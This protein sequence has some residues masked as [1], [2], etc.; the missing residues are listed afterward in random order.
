M[1]RTLDGVAG[2]SGRA[3]YT[4]LSATGL[5]TGTALGLIVGTGQGLSPGVLT[6]LLAV[7]LAAAGLQVA[8]TL[9]ISGKSRLV[10]LRFFLA[11]LATVV[12]TLAMMGE[13]VLPYL[14]VY[15]P[16]F[17]VVHAFG[18]LGCLSAG[19]CHGR[20]WRWGISYGPGHTGT[21]VFA[22]YHGKRLFPLQLAESVWIAAC[23]AWAWAGLGSSPSPGAACATYL[24]LY[25][26]GRYCLEWG[27]GDRQRVR[28][29]PLSEAQWT[30]L[31]LS[32]A[33][34]AATLGGYLPSS[35][36][37]LGVMA[38]TLGL[39]AWNV[40]RGRRRLPL[41]LEQDLARALRTLDTGQE[42]PGIPKGVHR[43]R[44]AGDLRL[45][46]GGSTDGRWRH[47][48]L[49]RAGR[50]LLDAEAVA[51]ARTLLRLEP[52]SGE[53][54]LVGEASGVFH[55]I[56]QTTTDEQNLSLIP[57]ITDVKKRTRRL[58]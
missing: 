52:Q 37:R 29:G 55:L 24:V 7:S 4:A 18:R 50:P 1:S 14:D 31:G 33:V 8:L 28:I 57:P 30:T 12:G 23:V 6:L 47:W 45:S 11:S 43:A 48:T 36:W 54:T 3:A 58:R 32:G 26:M 38:C 53:T 44:A 10:F 13:S 9:W 41:D 2:A 51:C 27:R 42:I 17:G 35:P 15:V 34:L 16:A 40:A 20:P 56:H 49:S 19:C 39:G 21:P 25:A 5:A 46:R 22:A